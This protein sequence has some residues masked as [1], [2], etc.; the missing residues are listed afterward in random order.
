MQ[1][2]PPA[3]SL[4][5]AHPATEEFLPAGLG[6]AVG[7]LLIFQIQLLRL[8]DGLHV[9]ELDQV[10]VKVVLAGLVHAVGYKDLKKLKIQKKKPIS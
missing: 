2:H 10:Q 7:K 4:T 8:Q 5:P 9:P 3:A 6:T 1:C